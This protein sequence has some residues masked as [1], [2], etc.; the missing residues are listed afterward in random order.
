MDMKNAFLKHYGT[1]LLLLGLVVGGVLG[2][3][4]GLDPSF[5]AAMLIIGTICDIPA[6][7]LNAT[8]NLVAPLLVQRLTP[9]VRREDRSLQA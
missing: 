9:A 7:L 4:L 6:T 5:A 3:V 2:A 8:G 1:T